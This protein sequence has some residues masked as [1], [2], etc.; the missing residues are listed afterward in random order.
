MKKFSLLIMLLLGLVLLTSCDGAAKIPN[1]DKINKEE[2]FNQKEDT[3]YIYFHKQNC[4][5]CTQANDLVSQYAQLLKEKD[6]CSVKRKLYSVLLYTQTEKPGED[7][8]IFREYVGIDGQGNEG[9]FFVKDVLKWEDL[10]IASTSSLI[11]IR[12]N[13][14]GEKYA[15]FIAQGAQNVTDHLVNQLGD[16]YNK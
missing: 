6:A 14:D 13:K 8:Y 10:Y 5:D 1:V 2:I 11:I 16:C 4:S 3:Y 7:I 9:K 15:S 12:T